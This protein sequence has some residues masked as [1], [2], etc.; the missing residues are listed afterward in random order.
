MDEQ[1]TSPLPKA[2]VVQK[3]ESMTFPEAIEQVIKGKRIA[4]IDWP[5]NEDF[6][7][8]KDGFLMIHNERGYHQWIVSDGDLLEDDWVVLPEVN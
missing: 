3:P 6:G 2:K 7:L 8:L 5:S 1:T 4:R